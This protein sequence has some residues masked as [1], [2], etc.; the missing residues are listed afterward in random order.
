MAAGATAEHE[1]AAGA[2]QAYREVDAQRRRPAVE[3]D[4]DAAVEHRKATCGGPHEPGL[5]VLGGFLEHL[6]GGSVPDAVGA[7]RP[8][9]HEGGV[10]VSVEGGALA[11]TPA[12]ARAG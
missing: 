4:V 2:E 12:H 5:H 1:R 11:V 10:R 9:R 6:L 3:H 7:D 8:D